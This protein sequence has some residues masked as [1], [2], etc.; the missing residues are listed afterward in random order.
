MRKFCNG[1]ANCRQTPRRDF[2]RIAATPLVTGTAATHKDRARIEASRIYLLES[3]CCYGSNES[4]QIIRHNR[5][6]SHPF[7][8]QVVAPASCTRWTLRGK[9]HGSHELQDGFEGHNELQS[10]G[11][12]ISSDAVRYHITCSQVRLFGALYFPKKSMPGSGEAT[13]LNT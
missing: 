7:Q 10:K 11:L 13:R 5:S 6:P 4:Q 1:E 9:R 3:T 12:Y 2:G 8:P